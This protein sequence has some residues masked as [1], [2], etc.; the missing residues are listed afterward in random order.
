MEILFTNGWRQCFAKLPI[1]K[2]S[3]HN[4]AAICFRQKRRRG[5][6]ENATFLTCIFKLYTVCFWTRDNEHYSKANYPAFLHETNH[7]CIVVSHVCS[8]E[9]SLFQL[10]TVTYLQ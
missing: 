9:T 5:L 4:S 3:L 1:L 8:R 2:L 6:P 7:G 10:K